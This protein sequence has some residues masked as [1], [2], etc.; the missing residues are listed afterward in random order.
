MSKKD[1]KYKLIR[2]GK[3]EW[4]HE[5]FH[6]PSR[7]YQ[8]VALQDIPKYGVKAGDLGGFVQDKRILSQSGDC[9]VAENAK[10][11]GYVEIKDDAYV[12]G[13]VSI[14]NNFSSV[15]L[16]ISEEAS[17]AGHAKI[18]IYRDDDKIA[19]D[20]G[21]HISD[22]VSISGEAVLANVRNVLG[23]T[24]ISGSVDLRACESI[25]GN[26]D[27]S[28]EAELKTGISLIDTV[29]SGKS[30]IN[31][32]SVLTGCLVKDAEVPSFAQVAHTTFDGNVRTPHA[33]S[34][35]ASSIVENLQPQIEKSDNEA[36]PSAAIPELSEVMLTF[37]EIKNSIASYETDIVKLIKYPLMAD[38]TDAFTRAMVKALNIAVRLSRKP[39]TAEFENA[40][41]ELED[42]FLAA[43]SNALKVAST[44]LSDEDRKKAEKARDLL[45]VASNEASSEHEKKVSFKQAFKQLEGVIAVPEVAV[46]TFRVK[47]GLQE[48]ESL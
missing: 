13:N 10:V 11:Y 38:R 15:K 20:S 47:I 27:I 9:W 3:K 23:T 21:M 43:E 39:E 35:P 42:A 32:R 16:I 41:S 1:F 30:V 22:Q 17:V 26:S 4:N 46:D 14:L 2:A 7:F 18:F 8:L 31:R 19:P 44:G 29:V 25:S 6:K 28:G 5:D 48:L 45:A 33:S 24:K 37:N 36:T 12:G 34:L 40:V